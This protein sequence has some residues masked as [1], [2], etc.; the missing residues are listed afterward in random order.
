MMTILSFQLIFLPQQSVI[1]QRDKKNIPL[2]WNSFKNSEEKMHKQ[3]TKAESAAIKIHTGQYR[4]SGEEYIVHPFAVAQLISEYYPN[5]NILYYSALFHDAIENCF[6]DSNHTGPKI[7]Q[8]FKHIMHAIPSREET[9]IVISLVIC[10]TK[11]PGEDYMKYVKKI[12]SG[13]LREDVLKIKI[14]D[15][16]HNL[17]S[18]PS[19]K[20][21]QKY[22]LALAKIQSFFGGK[23][24]M[25]L[26]EQ[27]KSVWNKIPPEFFTHS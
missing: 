15:M 9:C 25:I 16:E 5:N 26:S 13:P 22:T 10:L 27:W 8:A 19:L 14:A 11:L 3:Y 24:P 17:S 21:V 18:N 4:R 2:E 20:Q 1:H 12:Y 7:I 6:D 23:P